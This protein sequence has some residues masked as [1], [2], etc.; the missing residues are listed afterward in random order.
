MEEITEQD[1]VDEDVWQTSPRF[2]KVTG[3]R[4]GVGYYGGI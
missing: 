3:E 1:T 4:L 2:D